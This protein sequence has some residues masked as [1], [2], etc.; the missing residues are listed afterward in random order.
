MCF[1]VM[2]GHV[3]SGGLSFYLYH[4]LSLTHYG[5]VFVTQLTQTC[6][7]SATHM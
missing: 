6:T 4:T 1:N 2:L 3:H 7:H 5:N